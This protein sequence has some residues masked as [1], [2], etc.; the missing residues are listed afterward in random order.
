MIAIVLHV[1]YTE[2]WGYYE[3]KLQS[4]E[5]KFDLYITLCEDVEDITDDILRS[6]PHASVKK[7]PNKG[8]DI[9]PFLL[10]IKDIRHK[11]YD[12]LIKLHTKGF[13]RVATASNKAERETL[14]RL[15]KEWRKVLVQALIGSDDKI[16]ENISILTASDFKMCGAKEWNFGGPYKTQARKWACPGFA[17]Q[18]YRFIGGTMFMVD[19]KFFTECWTDL[20]IDITYSQLPTE[21]LP[22]NSL[23][24]YLERK[25]GQSV[26]DAGFEI[27][28]V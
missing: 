2:L 12:Y 4:L 11:D 14:R 9:G 8:Q 1:Y 19:F 20:V 7:Y 3:R 13:G 28:G 17:P 16:K 26:V 22:D 25:L 27:K 21:Y 10:T 15:T 24:H 18:Y 6:F 23:T 5:T